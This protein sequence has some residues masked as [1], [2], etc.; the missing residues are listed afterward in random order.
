M[1]EIAGSEYCAFMFS[2]PPPFSSNFTSMSS[3][4]HCSK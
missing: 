4:S 1:R 3:R 2:Q